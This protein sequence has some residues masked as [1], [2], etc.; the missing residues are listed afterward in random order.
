MES[1]MRGKTLLKTA[2]KDDDAERHACNIML[3]VHC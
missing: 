1:T 3:D 2:L